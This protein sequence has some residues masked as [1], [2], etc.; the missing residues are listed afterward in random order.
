MPPEPTSP[1][2]TG[3]NPVAKNSIFNLL[4]QALPLIAGFAAIPP[5]LSYLGPER[6][7]VLSVAWAILGYFS[8]FDFGV[9]RAVTKFVA[10]ARSAGPDGDRETAQIYW[11]G[12]TVQ[13][14]V[15]A[16]GTI[17]IFF[18][19]PWLVGR[20]LKLSPDLTF[21]AEQAFR[22]LAFFPP[23]VLLQISFRAMLEGAQ[24]FDLVNLI[25]A[26]AAASTFAVPLFALPFGL[27]LAEIFD[28]LL[29]SRLFIVAI[30]WKICFGVFPGLFPPLKPDRA[31]LKKLLTFGGWLTVSNFLGPIFAYLERL[32]IGSLISMTALAFYTAPF[33]VISRVIIVPLSISMALFPA[34]C[35]GP[36][37][38]YGAMGRVF[39]GSLKYIFLIMTPVCLAFFVYSDPLLNLW[40][41]PEYASRAGLVL[42]IL[43]VKFYIHTF[44]Y[45]PLTAVQALGRPDLKA[46][47]D[48]AVLPVFVGC[49]FV[50]L[51]WLGLPGA[52]WAKFIITMIDTV[53]LFLMAAYVTKQTVFEMLDS[54]PLKNAALQSLGLIAAV[55]LTELIPA[56]LGLR[57][58]LDLIWLTGF[59]FLFGLRCLED[60][61]R[62]ALRRAAEA[63]R[64]CRPDRTTG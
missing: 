47:L 42:K 64:I 61:E 53:G 46:K 29:I 30:Y 21:E 48:M 31:V 37:A 14:A 32:F 23:L 35:A 19:S 4:G 22:V 2:T 50:L 27:S 26:P 60:G 52:A 10:A 9:S 11:S 28:L 45:L 34:L 25:K 40:L 33:E 8:M 62:A 7:G 15:G 6:F 63:A 38:G 49:C 16:M 58:G 24:R 39:T 12:L 51:P 1:P 13:L 55:L 57:I 3:K 56:G 20:L 36:R 59:T 41:G 43:A 44:A 17:V 5:V 54:G 18:T